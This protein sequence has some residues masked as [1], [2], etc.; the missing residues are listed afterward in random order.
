MIDATVE[1][2]IAQ[3]VV[4]V[5]TVAANTARAST[6]CAT[7]LRT[8]R[9]RRD[10]RGDQ[11]PQLIRHPLVN[12]TLVHSRHDLPPRS[13]HRHLRHA[14]TAGTRSVW[15]P[16]LAHCIPRFRCNQCPTCPPQSLRCD[17]MKVRALSER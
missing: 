14:L 3:P 13:A 12:H 16:S 1:A 2:A 8:S 15:C 5:Y 10:Q 9:R 7:T 17:V 11:L 6:R 4:N